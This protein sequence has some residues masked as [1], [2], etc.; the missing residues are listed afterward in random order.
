MKTRIFWAALSA[1]LAMVACGGG[2]EPARAVSATDVSSAF[3]RARAPQA[4]PAGTTY[5]PSTN[6]VFGWAQATFPQWFEPH[7]EAERFVTLAPNDVVTY[8]YYPV[9]GNYLGVSSSG[10]VYVLGPITGMS[11]LSVG[12]AA[13]FRCQIFPYACATQATPVVAPQAP[14]WPEPAA[15]DD[16]VSSA[17]QGMPF[18]F[19]HSYYEGQNDFSLSLHF[20][21][22]MTGY[23]G[24]YPPNS[25]TI[26]IE[27]PHGLLLPSVSSYELSGSQ[28]IS[29]GAAL[30]APT[31]GLREGAWKVHVCLAPDCSVEAGNS[32]LL[33]P[34]RV[35]V[36]P[37]ALS[38]TLN[39]ISAKSTFGSVPAPVDIPLVL[40]PYSSPGGFSLMNNGSYV[41]WETVTRVPWANA[42]GGALHVEFPLLPVG[43][44]NS[45][46]QFNGTQTV[47]GG[48]TT[49]FTLKVPITYEVVANP[50]VDHAFT[51]PEVTIVRQAGDRT[52]TEV[53]GI[54]AVG[55]PG[56]GIF[57]SGIEFLSGPAS[58]P[59]GAS[60]FYIG[61]GGASGTVSPCAYAPP[62]QEAKCLPPGT[63]TARILYAMT[64][65]N[66]HSVVTRPVTLT[67][68]P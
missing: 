39:P 16:T 64:K 67:L 47:P 54:G 24:V 62:G 6:E 19:A 1:A 41:G 32:P 7:G 52:S 34:Y 30:K 42:T 3:A 61:Y 63:Y 12:Q 31:L 18:T 48:I 27:D 38:T 28:S 65:G 66:V 58:L 14:A 44:Y 55:A 4:T 2:N 53:P 23:F 37:A 49:Y 22:D 5:T 21:V 15:R 9:T 29:V 43:T 68:Y 59:D 60:W 33:L 36:S 11:L 8:R 45:T 13:D 57:A 56:V 51:T 25:A 17:I 50:A 26:R 20:Y 35:D 10:T 40:P 46:L